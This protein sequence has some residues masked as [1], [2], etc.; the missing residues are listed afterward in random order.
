MIVTTLDNKRGKREDGNMYGA[1][2]AK[3]LLK[4]FSLFRS[5]LF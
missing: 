5:E 1:C 4:Y 2:M 3:L